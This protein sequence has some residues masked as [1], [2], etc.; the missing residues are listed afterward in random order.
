MTQMSFLLDHKYCI[1]CQTCV[2]AC[3]MR[4]RTPDDVQL[5]KATSFEQQ[6]KGPWILSLIHI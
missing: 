2:T 4:H 5:R 1:G 3:Q 6:M